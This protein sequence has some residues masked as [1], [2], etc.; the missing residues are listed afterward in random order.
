M[1]EFIKK[2]KARCYMLGFEI[3]Y[4][5]FC[6]VL[7]IKGDLGL[8][9]Y[10]LVLTLVS[11]LSVLLYYKKEND[12]IILASHIIA[13]ANVIFLNFYIRYVTQL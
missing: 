6:T 3:F 13:L 2:N 7:G 5:V 10:S 11:T 12:Y 9:A 1:V 4:T 8:L